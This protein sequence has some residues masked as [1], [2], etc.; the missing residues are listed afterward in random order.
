[1]ARMS[2]HEIAQLNVG[3]AVAPLDSPVMAGFMNWLDEINALAE[4]HPGFVWR[5]QGDNGNNTSLKV[6]DDPLFI[7]NLS[8]WASIEALYDFT[9]R[10]AHKTVFKRRH[11]WFERMSGPNMVLWWQA[12]GTVPSVDEALA[13]LERLTT[14][15]PT[16]EAFSF[17]QRFSAPDTAGEEPAA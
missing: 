16:P 10:S 5:L 7:V 15:G 12:A 11:E 1:M 6:T 4:R 13:R 8:V 3:R 9:Y 14:L 2:A 17:M